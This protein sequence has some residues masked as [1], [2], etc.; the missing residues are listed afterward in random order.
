MIGVF[1]LYSAHDWCDMISCV[2]QLYSAH[3][4][5]D[6]ISCVFQL[7]SAHDW[8]DMISCVFQLYG[9]HDWCD[10][11]SCVFQ[12]YSAHDWCAGGGG[13]PTRCPAAGAAPDTGAQV[14]G[15]VCG[16]GRAT[17]AAGADPG[18]RLPGLP[19]SRHPHTEAHP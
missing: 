18:V 8:C 4:W 12:L 19:V 11:I 7:Y 3:D 6:M 16:A 10:M 2:F 17:A 1:Q 15:A 14:C 5:C 9:A 13:D